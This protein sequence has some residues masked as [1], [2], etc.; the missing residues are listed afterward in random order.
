[1]LRKDNDMAPNA[2]LMPKESMMPGQGG[3]QVKRKRLSRRAKLALIAIG[4][5]LLVA[6]GA[7]GYWTI[8]PLFINVRVSEALPVDNLTVLRQGTFV[9]ADAVVHKAEGTAKL[10]R[11]SANEVVVR[12]EDDFA[13][14]NGPD[15]Y[16]WLVRDGDV[17]NGYVD[18]GKLKGN[19]G[20]QNYVVPSGT[21][22]S[23]YNSVIIWCKAFSVLFG[24]AKLES[25]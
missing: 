7:F 1:M 11:T 8:S 22:L 19:V 20:S 25:L 13:A 5:P 12:F 2:G 16:V 21:N 3:M 23:Q 6:V 24:T 9:G 14:S 4:I 18:L 17:K 15:L 10:I